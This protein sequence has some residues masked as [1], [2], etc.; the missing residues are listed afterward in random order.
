MSTVQP[1][2]CIGRGKMVE[3]QLV[4][5]LSKRDMTSGLLSMYQ[6]FPSYPQ[7]A[8]KDI[9][10]F[11]SHFVAQNPDL[12]SAEIGTFPSFEHQIKLEPDVV[13]AAVK[14]RPIPFTIEDKV[15]TAVCLLDEQGISEPA[16][17]GDWAHPLVTPA[18]SDGT[19]R[20]TMDLSCLNCYVIPTQY[21]LPMLSEIFHKVQGSAFLSTLNLMKAYHHIMLHPESRPLTLAMTPL[22]PR[23]YMKM[24]LGLK[25]SGAIFQWAIRE[26]LKDCP[27]MIPYIDNILVCGRTKEEH[28][29]NLERVLHALH[30]NHFWLQLPKCHF[31]QIALAFLGHVLLDTELKPSPTTA[32]AILDAPVPQTGQQLSSFLGLVN[33]YT[34]FVPALATKAE[35]LHALRR[36][37]N[38]FQWSKECEKSFVEIKKSITVNMSLALHDPNAPTF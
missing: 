16:D 18:K 37:G 35:P 34:D 17:K 24:P 12:A 5:R 4:L 29:W 10:S 33:L 13:P 19:V 6:S 30:D 36:M 15:V 38:T 32:T 25:D 2:R 8:K 26:T 31:H 23:Q 27:G 14:A 7:L 11:V 1:S 20:V 3:L 28:D 9:P 22:G 21:P